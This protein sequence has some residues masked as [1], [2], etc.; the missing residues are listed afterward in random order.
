MQSAYVTWQLLTDTSA[1]HAAPAGCDTLHQEPVKEHGVQGAAGVVCILL[2]FSWGAAQAEPSA[3]PHDCSGVQPLWGVQSCSPGL[4]TYQHLS[5]IRHANCN[6]KALV[7]EDSSEINWYVSLSV[8]VVTGLCPN[9][10]R[11]TS[12]LQAVICTNLS[13]QKLMHPTSCSHLRRK[14]L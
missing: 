5:T 8:S 4:R 14:C 3:S 9:S 1:C 2:I 6:G 12:C 7:A 13:W 11:Q 10:K